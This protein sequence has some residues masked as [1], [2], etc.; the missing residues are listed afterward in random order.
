MKTPARFMTGLFLAVGIFFAG[1]LANR[2][3]DPTTSSASAEQAVIYTC[4]MHPQYRS[5][6]AGDCP[7]CG[8]RLE[9]ANI[10]A[11]GNKP[12]PIESRISGNSSDQ[13]RKATADRRP[14]G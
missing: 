12:D 10:G 6:R 4:P 1:Y 11:V 5:D 14:Y 7:I 13:R 2:Q 9:S 8:M 3:K